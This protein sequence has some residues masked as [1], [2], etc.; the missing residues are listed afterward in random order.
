LT[1]LLGSGKVA[2]VYDKDVGGFENAR[3]HHLDFVA[4]ARVEHQ[5]HRVR[6]T[7]NIDVGLARTN[8]FNQY[9]ILAHGIHDMNR[10]DRGSGEATLPPSAGQTADEDFSV[11]SIC[12]HP[13]A[14]AQDCAAAERAT[15][16]NGDDTYLHLSRAEL[17]NQTSNDRA[18]AH[19]WRSRNAHD[20]STT[21]AD[22]E[23]IK[24]FCCS[25]YLILQAPYQPGCGEYIAF[26]HCAC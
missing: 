11:N 25:I 21:S 22:V 10:A 3:L 5:Y 15:G 19:T 23:G 13:H 12:L 7:G 26:E 24:L 8:R 16:V 17:A 14:V 4:C 6:N 18:F 2:F 9:D 20:L 1:Q